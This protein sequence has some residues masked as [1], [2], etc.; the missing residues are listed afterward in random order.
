MKHGWISLFPSIQKMGWFFGFPRQPKWV[1]KGSFVESREVCPHEKSTNKKTQAKKQKCKQAP[2]KKTKNMVIS[3]VFFLRF[4]F[5]AKKAGSLSKSPPML[6]EGGDHRLPKRIGRV[7]SD[8]LRTGGPMRW[9]TRWWQLKHQ[10][11]L[12]RAMFSQSQKD[13]GLNHLRNG[14]EIRGYVSLQECYWLI[15]FYYIYIYVL[16]K[17]TSSNLLLRITSQ[18]F[19]VARLSKRRPGEFFSF[20]CRGC[21][22][23]SISGGSKIVSFLTQNNWTK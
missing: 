19:D 1:D 3:F 4:S 11:P 22:R 6:H 7:Q 9:M 12:E 21:Y 23:W 16:K 20:S 2:H 15:D 14:G 5:Q 18:H 13:H 10:Q 8:H 17:N